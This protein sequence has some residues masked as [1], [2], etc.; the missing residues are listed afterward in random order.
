MDLSTFDFR[1]GKMLMS[2]VN[3]SRQRVRYDS[4]NQLKV[5]PHPQVG[6]GGA[7][8]GPP[9]VV[10]GLSPLPHAPAPGWVLGLRA[11]CC[12]GWGVGFGGQW[13]GTSVCIPR[14]SPT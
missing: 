1:T 6:D 10:P 4:A 7:G 13:P 14:A 9:R 8:E 12:W 5:R 11:V 3:K 2:K